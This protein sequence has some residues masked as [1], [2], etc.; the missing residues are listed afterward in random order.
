MKDIY[1]PIEHL[2]NKECYVIDYLPES[3][4][5]ESNGQFF[6]VEYYVLN[7]NKMTQL[8]DKFVNVILKLMCYY[9]ISILP[10]ETWI[11]SPNPEMIEN[12]IT[13]RMV[14]HSGTLNCWFEDEDMLLVFDWDCLYLATY[15]V[16][17]KCRKIF[18]QIACSEGLF[19]RKS[20]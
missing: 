10:D 13:E 1:E 18:E 2:L 5:G 11:E 15:N 8:K 19:W 20:E 14:N 6:D 12:I 7:G 16:P 9:R 4:S 3:V 17:A